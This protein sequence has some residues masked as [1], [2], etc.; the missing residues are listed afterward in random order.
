[1]VR[2]PYDIISNRTNNAGIYCLLFPVTLYI[3]HQKQREVGRYAAHYPLV[4]GAIFLFLIVT[5]AS[6][7]L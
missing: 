6:V 2:S 4:F 3:L 1:M 5:I 7:D